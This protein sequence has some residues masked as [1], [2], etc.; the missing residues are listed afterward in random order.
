M[1]YE[2]FLCE[3][4][5]RA[6]FIDFVFMTSV[7]TFELRRSVQMIN[8]ASNQGIVMLIPVWCIGFRTKFLSTV[9]ALY[10]EVVLTKLFSDIHPE[11]RSI[12]NGGS[13]TYVCVLANQLS[14]IAQITTNQLGI[15]TLKDIPSV[16][17]PFATFQ[18][19]SHHTHNIPFP[20]QSYHYSC[21]KIMN[22]NCLLVFSAHYP[23]FCRNSCESQENWIWT[24][25]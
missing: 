6:T 8:K 11:Q 10:F 20:F 5:R 4:K 19:D 13:V 12:V 7:G 16:F 17:L 15:K 22:F 3:C 18:I 2:Q 23:I 14:R 25:C 24:T 1:C 9:A 21:Y